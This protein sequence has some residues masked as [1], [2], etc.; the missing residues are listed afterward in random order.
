MDRV[1][2]RLCRHRR[3]RRY[4]YVWWDGALQGGGIANDKDSDGDTDWVTAF[5]YDTSGRITKA[6]IDEGRPRDV[7]FTTDQSGMIVD[8]QEARIVSGSPTTAASPR[9]LRYFFAGLQLA[10]LGNNGT[11]NLEYAA[12]IKDRLVPA[13]TTTGIFRGGATYG[14]A[15]ADFEQSYDAINGTSS[16]ST[17]SS[18]TVQGGE[19]RGWL[20][21]PS[22]LLY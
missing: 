15:F 20:K 18:Y 12:S 10:Q 4:N 8:R 2:E 13:A 9:E 17:G 3:F 1:R 22:R 6:D 21:R 14:S 5:T 16:A 19:R 11:D 7:N